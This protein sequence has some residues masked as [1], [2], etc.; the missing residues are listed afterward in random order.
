M[1]TMRFEAVPNET[2]H[3]TEQA[4]SELR[5]RGVIRA[6]GVYRLCFDE[7]G[8]VYSVAVQKSLFPAD[9]AIMKTLTKWRFPPRPFT[10]CLKET[11]E[12]VLM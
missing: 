8:L 7:S 12:F 2:P 6:T 9:L 5:S 11:L 3:L 4:R 1:T 10:L